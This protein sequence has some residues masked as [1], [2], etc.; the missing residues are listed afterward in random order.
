MSLQAIA[1][2]LGKTPTT[3]DIIEQSKAGRGFPLNN[4]YDVFGSFPEAVRKAGLKS[5]YRQEFDQE[6]LLEEL[7]RL[8]VTLKRPLLGKDVVAARKNGKVSS[9]YHFQRAF[10]S[11]PKAIEVAGAGRKTYTRREMIEILRKID[12]E[13]D[14]P[15]LDF[16]LDELYHK[17]KG[18]NHRAVEREFGG[19]AKARRAAG[20]KNHFQKEGEATKYWQKYTL[21]K[22]TKQLKALGKKLGRKPTDRDINRASKEG[23]CASAMT[24]ARMFG[25]LPTAYKK[26][27]FEQAS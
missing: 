17:D 21:E 15:V 1:Q 27:G 2:R 26:A 22:L 11:V 6:K 23:L 14:R 16:D 19:M 25:N 18:P 5:K 10:G 9:I 3:T 7:R 13:L 24:F 20:V 12:A 8:R 4:Y